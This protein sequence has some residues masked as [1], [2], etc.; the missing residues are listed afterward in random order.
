MLVAALICIVYLLHRRAHPPST[1]AIPQAPIPNL[2]NVIEAKYP[3]PNETAYS[4]ETW[5][6]ASACAGITNGRTDV[7]N[8]QT[9][10]PKV[11]DRF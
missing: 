6:A 3:P 1:P 5:P 9:D 11:S 4:G 2:S 8:N 7:T 10:V